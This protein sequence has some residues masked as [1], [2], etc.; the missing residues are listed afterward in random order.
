MKF[1]YYKAPPQEI[2]DDIKENAMKIWNTYDDEFGYRTEKLNRIKDVGNIK[3]NAWCIV[4]MFDQSNQAQL[5]STVKPKTAEM[6]IK[7][8]GH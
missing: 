2:F 8:R 3:D 5:I 6:I 7:A 4:A 1:D